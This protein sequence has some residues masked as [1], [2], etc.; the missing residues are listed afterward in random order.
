MWFL[1]SEISKDPDYF[2]V[3][4]EDDEAANGCWEPIQR[5]HSL[6]SEQNPL[7][8]SSNQSF[9]APFRSFD[10]DRF[11]LGS[12]SS[13]SSSSPPPTPLRSPRELILA[14]MEEISIGLL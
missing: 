1:L 10:A 14:K 4:E 3:E 2:A 8:S 13:S 11:V 6:V 12:S 5:Q 7:N 9:Q